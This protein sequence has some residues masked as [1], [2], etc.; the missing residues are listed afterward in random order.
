MQRSHVIAS[1]SC[2]ESRHAVNLCVAVS[3][4]DAETS[5]DTFEKQRKNVTGMR[6]AL[7]EQDRFS[8]GRVS[9][10]GFGWIQSGKRVLREYDVRSG[11]PGRESLLQQACC[12]QM[13][14][15]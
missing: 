3:P 11:L 13:K 14:L 9:M 1:N 5:P 2:N 15:S 4:N 12:L 7:T 8:T 10:C 6:F